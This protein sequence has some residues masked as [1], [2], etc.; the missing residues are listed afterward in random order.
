MSIKGMLAGLRV[1]LQFDNW[2]T[3]LLNR[4]LDRKT[5][6]VVYRKDGLE[7]LID[8]RGG[9]QNGTRACLTTDMYQRYLPK[10]DHRGPLRVLDLGAN[11]GGFPLLLRL[12]SIDLA[13]VVC[14]EMNRPTWLRLLVNLE[15]NLGEKATGLNAVVSGMP[16]D[17]EILLEPSRGGAGLSVDR[18]RAD[19]SQPHVTVRTTTLESLYEQYFKGHDIDICKIDIEGAEYPVLGSSSD[20]VLQKIRNLIIEFHDP[21]QTPVCVSRL[22]RLGFTEITGQ[23]DAATGEATEVR[24]F[25]RD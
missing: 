22:L 10:I 8:H 23:G 25:S 20:H 21:A 17:S 13:R 5:G 4:T 12:S 6:L 7:I 18:N 11:G 9:D 1:F 16:A 2:P 24:A 14:V 15:T 19:S 3:L